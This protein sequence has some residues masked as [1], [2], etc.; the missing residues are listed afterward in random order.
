MEVTVEIHCGACGSANYSLP[1]SGEQSLLGC[2]DCGARLGSV[3]ELKAEMLALAVA[4]SAEARRRDL[5]GLPP[6]G[7]A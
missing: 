4:Q 2:N 5:S 1:E 6:R 7:A 3:A